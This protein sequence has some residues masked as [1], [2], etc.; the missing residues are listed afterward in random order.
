M[1]ELKGQLHSRTYKKYNDKGEL[2]IKTAHEFL[3]LDYNIVDE[4]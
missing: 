1:L 4:L 2:E 3:I